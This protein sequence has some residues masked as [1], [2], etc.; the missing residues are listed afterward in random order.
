MITKA[1]KLIDNADWETLL[2]MAGFVFDEQ[3]LKGHI[4]AALKMDEKKLK[5]FV[6][7]FGNEKCFYCG[8]SIN[9][10]D[11]SHSS[12]CRCGNCDC[13]GFVFETR[14]CSLCD[15]IV[16]RNNLSELMLNPHI[17]LIDLCEDHFKYV[18]S[19]INLREV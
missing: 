2:Q 5:D 11:F 9:Q 15:K 10:H 1:E 14:K 6:E 16:D 17:Q 12:E 4:Y 7:F 18:A 13:P 19:D 3:F 8:H